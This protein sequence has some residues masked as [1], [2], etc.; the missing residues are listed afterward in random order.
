MLNPVH[1]TAEADKDIKDILE[2]L[3]KLAVMGFPTTA[4]GKV[5]QEY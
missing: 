2:N 3:R 4:A 1:S 5:N